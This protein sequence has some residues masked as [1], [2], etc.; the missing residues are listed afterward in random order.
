MIRRQLVAFWVDSDTTDPDD[1]ARQLHSIGLGCEF[2]ASA[3]ET[4]DS[5]DATTDALEALSNM[6]RIE[7]AERRKHHL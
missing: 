6:L 5:Y 7:A 2:L 1:V 4:D 3:S